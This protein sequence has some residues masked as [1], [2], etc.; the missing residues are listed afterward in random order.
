MT[1]GN[2]TV[3]KA[4]YLLIERREKLREKK[5]SLRDRIDEKYPYDMYSIKGDMI[6]DQKSKD[7][8]DEIK[9]LSTYISGMFDL[10][11]IIEKK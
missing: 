4:M 10:I 3:N 9:L 1:S 7:L 11:E 5:Q 6:F 2:K 8:D